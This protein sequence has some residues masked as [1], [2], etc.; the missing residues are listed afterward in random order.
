MLRATVN[1]ALAAPATIENT[2]TITALE[3]DPVTVNN[4]ASIATNVVVAGQSADLT[5][6]KAISTPGPVLPVATLTYTITYSNLGPD[7]ASAVVLNDLLPAGLIDAQVVSS[8]GG[9]VLQP[10]TSFTW[11]IASLASGSGGTIVFRATVDPSLAAPTSLT[12]TA[13]ITGAEPDPLGS[14]NAASVSTP[15]YTALYLP[16]V[17]LNTP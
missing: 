2:A 11:S 7:A 9:A 1:P 3:L 13:S 5:V 16:A 4:T 17:Y 6:A 12:N 15:I 10:G 8:S 14:N